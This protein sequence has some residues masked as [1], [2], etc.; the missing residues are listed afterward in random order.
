[1]S[2]YRSH[3]YYLAKGAPLDAMV[4]EFYGKKTGANSGIAGSMELGSHEHNFY[5]GAIVG[6]S[7]YMPFGGAFAQKYRGG[8]DISVSVIGDGVFDE[9]ITYEIFNLAALYRL[10][11]L[12]ICE[13]NKYAAHTP[14]EKRQAVVQLTDRAQSF[15]IPFE[16]HDGYDAMLLLRTLERVVPE[17]RAGGGPR[18]IEI[19]TYRYC[20]HVGPGEDEGMGYRTAEEIKHWKMRNPVA[21][22]RRELATDLD[23]GELGRLEEAIEADIRSAVAVAKR[24][25][26]PNFQ[27]ILPWN[28][29]GEYSDVV[30][31]AASEA[32]G[33]GPANPKRCRGLSDMLAPD[34][35]PKPGTH[36]STPLTFAHAIN[37]ALRQAMELD[38]N[39][40][41]CG[42]GA[43]TPTRHIRH[44]D[45]PRRPLRCET[46]VRHPIAEAG[47]TALAAGAGNAGLRPV[48]VHQRLDFMLYSLDQVVNWMAPWRLMSGGRARWPVTIRAI[49]GKGWGQGPQHTKSLHTWFAHVPGLQVVMPRSPS[50]AKGLLLSSIMSDDPTIFIEGRAL[51]SM[52]RT[53]PT[54]P[55]YIRL[56]EVTLVRR[57]GKDVTARHHGFH[58]VNFAAGRRCARK[59]W[60]FRRGGRSAMSDAAR[61]AARHCLGKEDRQA[62]SGRARLADVRCGRA[63]SWRQ[64]W[65]PSGICA[66]VRSASHGRTAPFPPPPQLEEQFYPTR[67]T[68]RK[69]AARAS[70]KLDAR[71]SLLSLHL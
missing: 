68:S 11:L 21:T 20:G 27:E 14:I 59:I 7:L 30:E 4:A 48:I 5:S 34:L 52:Q 42:I 29:S 28:A 31:F 44:H 3:G 70:P 26:W 67:Q 15:G 57:E 39:V 53:F 71:G 12:I 8:E 41:V 1:M 63:R 38:P 33:S 10:P 43:D 37:A 22:L 58:G 36:G 32:R 45:R 69:R 35:K 61:L 13:N 46:R 18:C 64:W 9:G 47:I 17:I 2:H 19:A 54:R 16:K 6:G 40:F 24:A 23:G 65:R 62:G 25:P 60:C 55:I 56:G 50:D 66:A 51:F 49:I